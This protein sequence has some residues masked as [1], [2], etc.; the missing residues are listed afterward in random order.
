MGIEIKRL[1][2]EVTKHPESDERNVEL[3]LK[4]LLESLIAEQ[5]IL[6]HY[7]SQSQNSSDTAEICGLE[8]NA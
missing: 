2:G 1:M 6:K 4:L 5:P 3:I 7:S 8:G